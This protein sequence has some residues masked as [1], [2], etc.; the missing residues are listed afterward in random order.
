[1]QIKEGDIAIATHGRG[2]WILDD[3]SVFQQMTDVPDGTHLFKPRDS[4]R[5]RPLRDVPALAS[6][7]PYGVFINY[8]LEQPA[9]NIQLRFMEADGKLIRTFKDVP[10]KAGLNR[11]IWTN[12]RYPGSEELEGHPTR[13]S[14]NI[15]PYALPGDYRVE[16]MVDGKSYSQSFSL[17]KD[18]N[19]I[20][21]SQDLKQQF[22]FVSEVRDTITHINRTV[23]AIREIRAGILDRA[24]KSSDLAKTVEN[25]NDKLYRLEDVLT[26]YTA[27]YRMEYHAK[28]T[29]LD[30]K[31]YNL[32][33]HALRGD[34]R[35]TKAQMELFE[36][37]KATY[38]KVRD[39]VRRFLDKDLAVFNAAAKSAGLKPVAIPA[40]FGPGFNSPR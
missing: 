3:I 16:L 5:Y 23:L 30:D 33:G 4:Y 21:S 39:G 1:M 28:A 22:D 2:F 13:A 10:N 36:E 6:P 31:L 37:H 35:P 34:A 38:N 18:P 15:G 11:F 8:N 29:K 25:L 9:Q 40:H 19:S 7:A 24:K 12:Q 27:V 17:K 32:A 20:A 26:A 14:R